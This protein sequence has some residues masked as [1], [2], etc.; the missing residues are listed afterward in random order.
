MRLESGAAE[1]TFVVLPNSN[2][3]KPFGESEQQQESPAY[4]PDE[5]R[6]EQSEKK[7]GEEGLTEYDKINK[8]FQAKTKPIAEN[9]DRYATFLTQV[10]IPRGARSKRMSR[11]I[12]S[13]RKF[14]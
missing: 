9:V 7:P 1:G 2:S 14:V 6:E 11:R 8:P 12:L 10:K 4:S 3:P 13:S 5:K